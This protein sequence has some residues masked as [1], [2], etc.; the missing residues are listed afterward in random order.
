M[1][2]LQLGEVEMRDLDIRAAGFSLV[3][4]IIAMFLLGVVAVA[5]L[6][7]LWQG[8]VLSSQQASTAT[9]TRYMNS[10]VDDARATPTCSFLASISALPGVTDGR[11]VSLSTSTTTVSGCAPGSTATLSVE[12]VGDGRVLASTTALI[13]V[14]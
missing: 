7:A 13:F 2:N 9:A 1:G 12:V 5:I 4:V 6:P 11:G 3:E 14:P 10:I 8:I